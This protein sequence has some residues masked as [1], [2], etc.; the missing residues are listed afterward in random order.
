MSE[1]PGDAERPKL[2][3]A[4]LVL[5]G[6]II[7][8]IPTYSLLTKRLLYPYDLSLLLWMAGAR[9]NAPEWLRQ[10]AELLG[11][12]SNIGIA[13]TSLILSIYWWRQGRRARLVL[14]ALVMVLGFLLFVGLGILFGRPRPKQVG[15]VEY[16]P[17]LAYPSGHAQNS[18]AFAVL[19]LYLYLHRLH[20]TLGRGLVLLVTALLV[21]VIGVTRLFQLTHYMTDVIA[22]YGVG[23]IW[24][25]AMI[26]A[27]E[28]YRAARGDPPV[29]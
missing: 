13:A 10:G 21:L 2:L 18:L 27:V 6:L 17:V 14:I 19:L 23:L 3:A 28:R 26:I 25:V 15:L 12:L 4:A 7:F 1:R 20:S 11:T 5:V 8:A 9:A 16:I 24:S 29:R 22:G